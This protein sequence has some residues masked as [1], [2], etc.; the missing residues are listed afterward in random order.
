MIKRSHDV[1]S[2]RVKSCQKTSTKKPGDDRA[3]DLGDRTPG[4]YGGDLSSGKYSADSIL[5]VEKKIQRRWR[6]GT[7][8]DEAW[9]ENKR[10]GKNSTRRRNQKAEVGTCGVIDRAIIAEKKRELGLHGE[11]KGRHLSHSQRSALLREIESAAIQ[12]ESFEAVCRVLELNPRAVYRWKDGTTS[13]QTHGGGGGKNK[14]TPL[15]EK[16]V[17][18]LAKKFPEWRCRRIAYELERQAKVFIGK[19]KV[20]EILKKHGLNHE[21]ERGYRKPDLLP[22]EMLNRKSSRFHA[23]KTEPEMS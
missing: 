19:T 6:G 23:L 14:I 21:F 18:A 16:R 1:R 4:Q 10:S 15:E 17:V 9:S 2:K 13:K 3:V 22:G 12:G 7:H 20:A 5:C 8:V 11:L